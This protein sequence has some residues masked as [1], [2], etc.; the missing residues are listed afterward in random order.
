MDALQLKSRIRALGYTQ[1]IAA[2]K[3]GLSF[4]GL[5]KQLYGVHKVSKQTEL[6]I[7]LLELL[8]RRSS[9]VLRTMGHTRCTPS[10][11][12]ITTRHKQL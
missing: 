6:I 5:C 12:A 3:L 7:E 4:G 2:E 8:E 1:K 9:E 10:R 11:V